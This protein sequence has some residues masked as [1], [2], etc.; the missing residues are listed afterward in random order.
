[1]LEIPCSVSLSTR[2]QARD[3]YD[4]YHLLEKGIGIDAKLVERKLSRYGLVYDPARLLERAG[5]M[6]KSWAGLGN[7]VYSRLPEFDH[8]LEVL[9][10][11]IQGTGKA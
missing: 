6:R 1:M 3:L 2:T 9:R 10:A 7:L 8:A 4:S 5:K 11:G